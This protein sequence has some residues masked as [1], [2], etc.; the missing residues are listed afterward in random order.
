[1]K[2][3]KLDIFFSLHIYLHEI[4]WPGIPVFHKPQGENLRLGGLLEPQADISFPKALAAF[5][6]WSPPGAWDE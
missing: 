4:K 5:T 2:N 6:L 1:M 3:N